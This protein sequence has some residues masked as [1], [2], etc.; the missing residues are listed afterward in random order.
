[1]NAKWNYILGGVTIGLI[2]GG[3]IYAIKKAK[4]ADREEEEA[5]TLD[6]ARR[7][8]EE[9]RDLEDVEELQGSKR[10]IAVKT[11]DLE[12]FLENNE[13]MYYEDDLDEEED[14]FIVPT[15]SVEPL[16]DF[17]YFEE[18]IDNPGEDTELRFDKNSIDAKHQ[19]IRMELADFNGDFSCDAYRIT[20]QLFEFPFQPTNSG[21]ELLRTQI[22][23]YKVQFFGF[24]SKWVNEVS[25]ADVILYYAR[26]AEYDVGETV[27]YWINYF[28]E[29]NDFQWDGTSSEYDILLRRLNSHTYFNEDRQTFG[30]FG[31]SREGMD[32]AINIAHM[33]IDRSV[34]YEIEFQE[35]LKSC[36]Q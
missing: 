4:D 29:F 19:F 1:M 3:T 13:D 30:L 18:G 26:R 15:Y 33:N 31:L 36:I 20:L 6:E 25:Y 23:D 7:I 17:L 32:S 10:T 8:V 9:G 34:T 22:I 24:D 35:F 28:L 16:Y 5:I 14:E 11:E 21:D 27:D 12:T 2:I